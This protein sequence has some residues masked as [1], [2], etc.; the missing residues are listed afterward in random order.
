MN[1]LK[2]QEFGKKHDF[3]VTCVS[4]IGILSNRLACIFACSLFI[5][6]ETTV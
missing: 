3:G 6:R 4:N 5:K 2:P 1:G